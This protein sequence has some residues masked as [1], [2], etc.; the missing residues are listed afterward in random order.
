M[1][2]SCL[3]GK[4]SPQTKI[5]EGR[6]REVYSIDGKAVK[7]LK[8]Y[9]KK[10][11][12]L[13]SLSFPISAY[14]R[15]KYGIPDFN[16]FEYD[17]F[18]EILSRIPSDMTKRFMQVYSAGKVNKKSISISQLIT[19]WNGEVS[20]NLSQLGPIEDKNFWDEVNMLE[21][22]LATKELFILD[23]RG[24]NLAV[25]IDSAGRPLP[26]MIDYKRFGQHTYPV[27][28]WLSD[29]NSLAEKLHRRFDR[30]RKQFKKN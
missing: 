27:Q 6:F 13:F 23:V 28:F 3:V 2:L 1:D 17:C 11:Y 4:V 22:L 14:T 12:G 9:V 16:Q 19:D 21:D 24:E 20:K 15:L 26:V 8:P 25:Q 5:G 29:N 30:L 10:N 7:I 18:N